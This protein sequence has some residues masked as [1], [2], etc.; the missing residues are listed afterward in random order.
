MTIL[1]VISIVG[2]V[3]LTALAIVLIGLSIKGGDWWGVFMGA[4]FL[5]LLAFLADLLRV[6]T[7]NRLKPEATTRP[8]LKVFYV[9]ILF[10]GLLAMI[11]GIKE[12]LQAQWW[13]AAK[14]LILA[15]IVLTAVIGD[16]YLGYRSQR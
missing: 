8:S 6:E 1:R 13:A 12:L 15:S 11:S 4:G 10:G 9:F 7:A 2:L 16:L 3:I 5:S 14:Y